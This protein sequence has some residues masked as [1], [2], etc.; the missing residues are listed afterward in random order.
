MRV[1]TKELMNRVKSMLTEEQY[2]NA[3]QIAKA[4][5]SSAGTVFRIIR[6][7]RESGVGVHW[8]K[9]GYTLSE[10]ATKKDDV[11][12]LHRLCGRRASDFIA[13]KKINRARIQ[14]P[15]SNDDNIVM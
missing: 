9:A 3:D 10:Y 6:F 7:L 12:Y 15:K 1:K 4:L 11:D 5:R 8:T 2:Q 13:I 14:K